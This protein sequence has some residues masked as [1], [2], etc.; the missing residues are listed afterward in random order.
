MSSNVVTSM[1]NV[2]QATKL[3]QVFLIHFELVDASPRRR[4]I[5]TLPPSRNSNSGGSSAETAID[6]SGDSSS[7]STASGGGSSSLDKGWKGN[8]DFGLEKSDFLSF[9]D[10]LTE[11]E[12]LRRAMAISLEESVS[13]SAASEAGA[14]GEDGGALSRMTEEEQLRKG[15]LKCDVRIK[16]WIL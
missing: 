1:K 2:T 9:N 16:I 8:S 12:A 14:G 15:R 4:G 6:L 13:S 5:K 11:D 10:S 3:T 7:S